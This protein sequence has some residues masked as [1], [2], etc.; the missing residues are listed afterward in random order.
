MQLLNKLFKMRL[1]INKI[2]ILL[3]IFSLLGF[4]DATY[5]TITH[6]KNIIP[7]CTIT[8]GCE[9]VL[10]SSFA[11][12]LGIP[13]AMYGSFYFFASTIINILIFQHQKNIWIRRLF[14]AFHSSGLVAA[15]VLLFL[16]FVII[17]ALC[18]YCMLVELLLILMF[19][20]ATLFLRKS[21]LTQ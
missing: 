9:K 4:I 14:M 18:Q 5:L 7:P 10:S 3:I 11:V 21:K 13:M 6:Y 17:K 12:I 8:H 19:G 2:F 20:Y 16:Q 15:F 1:T